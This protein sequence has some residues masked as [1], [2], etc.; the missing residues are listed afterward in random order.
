MRC[1]DHVIATK[2]IEPALAIYASVANG[3]SSLVNSDALTQY[4]V[5]ALAIAI[6]FIVQLV[7]HV[8]R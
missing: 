1:W 8:L 6:P 7:W 5:A 3:K 4:F 2:K